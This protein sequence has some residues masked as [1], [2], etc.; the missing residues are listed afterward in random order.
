[1]NHDMQ[2]KIAEAINSAEYTFCTQYGPDQPNDIA[3]AFDIECSNS[4][5]P[6]LSTMVLYFKNDT[7]VLARF[8]DKEEKQIVETFDIDLTGIDIVAAT[9]KL[10]HTLFVDFANYMLQQAVK[11]AG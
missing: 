11:D 1:M 7:T 2:D 9:P 3:V 8:F 10:M 5:L 6:Q 4:A